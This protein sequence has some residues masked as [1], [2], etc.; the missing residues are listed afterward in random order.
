MRP[1]RVC[2]G[3]SWLDDP[4]YCRAACRIFNAAPYR[5]GFVGFRVARRKRSDRV[6]RGGS[7]FV[8]PRPCR[9]AY[10]MFIDAPTQA[11]DVG[12]RITRRER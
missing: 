11:T 9:A 2:R 6:C 1:K 12:F 7:R 4:G 10:R 3:G 5:S 8:D